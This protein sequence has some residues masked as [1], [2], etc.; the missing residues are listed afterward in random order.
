MRRII[1]SVMAV[2]LLLVPATTAFAAIGDQPAEQWSLQGDIRAEKEMEGQMFS[3]FALSSIASAPGAAAV[4]GPFGL[5]VAGAGAAGS[6]LAQIASPENAVWE[7]WPEARYMFHHAPPDKFPGLGVMAEK[8]LYSTVEFMANM[9]FSITKTLVRTSNNIMVLAFN[10]SIVS[11]MVGWVSEGMAEIFSPGGDLT[12]VLLATGLIILLVFGIFNILKGQAMSALTSLLVAVLAVGGAFFF[13]TNARQIISSTAGATDS[14]AGVFLATTGRYTSAG[15]KVNVD[16]PVGRGLVAAGQTTWRLI[17]ANPWALA[18][19]GTF[20]EGRLRLTQGEY[21]VIDKSVF[22]KE[23]QGKIRPG[24][25]L[26]TLVLG[27]VGEGRDAVAEALARPN[28]KY[29]WVVDGKDIDHGGHDGTMVGFSPESA[30][31]H[32]KTALFTL[33]PATGFALLAALVGLSIVICQV[34][35]APLLLFLPL[36][37][38]AM[39]VPGAGWVFA[40]R[41]FRTLLGFFL[42]KLVYGLYLSLVLVTGTAFSGALING[43]LGAAMVVLAVIF[44]AAAVYRKKFLNFALESVQKGALINHNKVSLDRIMAANAVLARKLGLTDIFS[45]WVFS[46]RGRGG[47]LGRQPSPG[48]DG[49]TE[50]AGQEPENF[51]GRSGTSG[52]HAGGGEQEARRDKVWEG[53]PPRDYPFKGLP[54]GRDESSGGTGSGNGGNPSGGR[55]D[56]GLLDIG[57][58]TPGGPGQGAAATGGPVKVDAVSDIPTEGRARPAAMEPVALSGATTLIEGGAE[59]VSGSSGPG[60]AVP[61]G[62]GVPDRPVKDAGRL[63]ITAPPGGS[64]GVHEERNRSV[65]APAGTGTGVTPGAE[66]AAGSVSGRS[67]GGKRQ[68]PSEPAGPYRKAAAPERTSSNFNSGTDV[69]RDV[70]GRPERFHP[71]KEMSRNLHQLPERG[72]DRRPPYA[73]RSRLRPR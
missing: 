42:V 58:G 39:M 22:P 50:T 2:F 35:L 69:F 24:M 40:A 13:T 34:V 18:Q 60:A 57:W 73:P 54:A 32:L 67:P 43:N 30:I 4:S 28:K 52:A 49:G 6:G 45:D 15:R 7:N 23:S 62:S 5:L 51:S 29:L 59:S 26:D 9:V 38:F 55:G 21:D 17:V 12:Q 71:D 72:K 19:F 70:S 66:R 27:S 33:L 8:A 10:T 20:D 41:Y 61:P 65:P 63:A 36:P 53:R 56:G 37:F 64:G 48:G 11:G 1:Y 25:R 68:Y 14:L 47:G 46:G 31:Q 3:I 44:F 16:D